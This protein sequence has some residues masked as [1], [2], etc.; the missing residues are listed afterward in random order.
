MQARAG[1][2]GGDLGRMRVH[3][4]LGWCLLSAF[5]VLGALLEGMHAFKLGWYLDLANET[6]R[7]LLR[8]AHA[9]G[10]LLGLVNIAFALSLPHRAPHA[11][12]VERWISR[13]LR[14]GS[15]LLPTGFL[16][17]G[18]VVL[19]GDPNPAVLLAPVGAALLVAGVVGVAGGF[20]S[21]RAR[22][23]SDPADDDLPRSP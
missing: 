3:L 10:V 19:G 15:V 20:F 23:A 17:G 5:L 6:R 4:R 7:L 8:L 9:H 2:S 16:L 1:G 14:F 11:E 12:R 22:A 21:R 18:L 13:C